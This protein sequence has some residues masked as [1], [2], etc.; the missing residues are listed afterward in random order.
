MKMEHVNAQNLEIV[1]AIAGYA[2]MAFFVGMILMDWRD[3][4][5]YDRK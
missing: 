5:K 2:L 1:S 3:S 4:K